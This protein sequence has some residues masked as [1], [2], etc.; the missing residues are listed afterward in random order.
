[1]RD[2]SGI[3]RS[4]LQRFLSSIHVIFTLD[5]SYTTTLTLPLFSPPIP[6]ALS[7]DDVQKTQIF[8]H[9][10]KGEGDEEIDSSTSNPSHAKELPLRTSLV[11]DSV[12]KRI[13]AYMDKG[14]RSADIELETGL[15]HP[16]VKHY[17]RMWKDERHDPRLRSKKR[18]GRKARSRVPSY[19]PV[20]LPLR[21]KSAC[22]QEPESSQVTKSVGAGRG[23]RK[24]RA[25]RV[26]K[27]REAN[28][29]REDVGYRVQ[30]T[31]SVQMKASG[32]PHAIEN[33]FVVG[34]SEKPT[35]R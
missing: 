31:M 19:E 26:L 23:K 18:S 6:M 5:S 4:H 11:R 33:E 22:G 2:G 27:E 13:F 1:M 29:R 28:Q 14:D 24:H 30:E 7:V 15:S 12:K 20:Q 35:L 21:L 10:A 3:R 9:S 25:A 16:R 32:Y 17:R 8:K 34:L